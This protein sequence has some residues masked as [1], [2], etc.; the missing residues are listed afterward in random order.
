MDDLELF[1]S[2]NRTKK[3]CSISEE[4]INI[5][6]LKKGQDFEC[7][8]SLVFKFQL[9]YSGTPKSNVWIPNYAKIWMPACSEFGQ[10]YGHF[11]PNAIEYWLGY[12]YRVHF[13][14]GFGHFL[15]GI[16]TYVRIPNV[17]QPNWSQLFQ[18]RTCSVLG[19]SLY[20]KLPI[21][22]EVWVQKNMRKGIQ[23]QW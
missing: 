20:Y 7:F 5:V 6:Q 8:R 2:E 19:H 13:Q 9:N 4:V 3:G 14:F 23:E 22:I 16:W 17:W 10:F 21:D 12:S 15:F 18:I 11:N 1:S